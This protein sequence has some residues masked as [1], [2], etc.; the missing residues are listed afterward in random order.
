[1]T[2][3]LLSPRLRYRPFHEEDADGLLAVFRAPEVRRYLLD[4]SL[5]DA[6]WLREEVEASRA[7]FDA[8]S[9]GLWSLRDRE[10]GSLVGFVGFRPFFDPPRVQLLYGLV[11]ERWGR[12]LATEAARAACV[13]AFLRLGWTRVEAATDLPNLRSQRVLR[14]LGMRRDRVSDDGESGTAFFSVDRAGWCAPRTAGSWRTGA[15]D[16]AAAGGAGSPTV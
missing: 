1:M 13:H 4:D 6:V 14:R 10:D 11:G 7:R 3:G 9:A 2:A 15:E 16:G 12:G 5:V 8:G